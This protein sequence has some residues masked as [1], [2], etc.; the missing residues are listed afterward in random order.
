MTGYWISDRLPAAPTL[1]QFQTCNALENGRFNMLF[2][3]DEMLLAAL[4]TGAQGAV[5]STSNIAA[6]LYHKAREHFEAGWLGE[7]QRLQLLSAQMVVLIKKYRPLPALQAMM[8]IGASST[9]AGSGCSLA[10]TS[11]RPTRKARPAKSITT[12]PARATRSCRR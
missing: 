8:K 6:P 3:T 2:G 4:A 11:I 5:R 7:A 1:Y 10:R 9:A 12:R